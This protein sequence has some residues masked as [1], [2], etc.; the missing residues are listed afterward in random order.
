[1]KIVLIG[2]GNVAWNLGKLFGQHNHKVLQ[3]VSRN[4]VT[5]TQLTIMLQCKNEQNLIN[6]NQEAD[7]YIICINDDALPTIAAELKN[8]NKLIVHT[9]GTVEIEIL[10]NCSSQFGALYPLQ[11]LV[12]GTTQI[13]EIPFLIT[14]NTTDTEKLLQQFVQSLQMPVSITNGTDKAKL[15][16]A[17]VLVNNFTNHLYTLAENWCNINNLDFKL[18]LPLIDQTVHRMHTQSPAVLQT[19]PAIRGD[20]TTIQKHLELIKNDAYLSELYK[21][22]SKGIIK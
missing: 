13:P 6:L 11:S 1:M 15:H 20:A 19:G 16:L 17:A 7:I 18:L 10:K 22:M 2:S 5:A 9:S 21:L 12:Y 3:V 8:L 4:K 14:G